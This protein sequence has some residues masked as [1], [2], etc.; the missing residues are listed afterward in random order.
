MYWLLPR[1]RKLM[2]LHQF[3]M[4]MILEH[5]CFVDTHWS[6]APLN[7]AHLFSSTNPQYNIALRHA[8]SWRLGSCL[9]TALLAMQHGD[10]KPQGG[11]TCLTSILVGQPVPCHVAACW[12]K[13]CSF[14]ASR[15]RLPFVGQVFSSRFSV[16]YYCAVLHVCPE[17]MGPREPSFFVFTS[18]SQGE[19]RRGCALM[20]APEKSW[21]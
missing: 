21:I 8:P 18:H 13:L 15:S 17:F 4:H 7:G 6:F 9:Q 1:R 16:Q 5:G 2:L 14:H 3:I 19:P 10:L 20:P 11:S 12:S